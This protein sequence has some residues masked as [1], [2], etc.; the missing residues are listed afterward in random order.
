MSED[1]TL[2]IQNLQKKQ[3]II[4]IKKCNEILKIKF[5]LPRLT[6]KE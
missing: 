2:A 4:D 1:F 6:E 5:G 3:L